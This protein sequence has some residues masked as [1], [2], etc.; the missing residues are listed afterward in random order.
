MPATLDLT[1][2]KRHFEE[3]KASAVSDEIINLNV[4]SIID[5]R[6]V[7]KILGRNT[8]RKWGLTSDL[9]P[10]WYA[11]GCDPLTGMPTLQGVQVKP[12]KAPT[13]Q[14]GKPQKY[15]GASG[16]ETAPLFLRTGKGDL[17]E[18]LIDDLSQWIFICEG[19]KK[20]GSLLSID[21]PAIS[22]PGVTTCRKLG[23]LHQN[24][25]LFAKPGRNI[26][27]SYDNDLMY[28]KGVQDGLE[29]LGRELRAAGAKVWVLLLPEGEAKGID[30]FLALHGEEAFRKLLQSPESLPTFEEWLEKKKELEQEEEEKTPKSKF[31]KKFY[32]IQ[33]AWGEDLRYNSLKQRIELKGR[34]LDADE[35]QVTLFEHFDIDISKQDAYTIVRTL[36]KRKTYSPVLDYL[37]EVE[38]KFPDVDYSF[39]DDLAKL[40]FGSDNPLHAKYLKNFLVA[41]VA[42]TRVPGIKMDCAVLLT[43]KQGAGKSTFWETLFGKDFFSDDFG[44]GSDKDEKMKMHRF[45][46]LEWSE[47]TSVYKRKDIEQLKNFIARKSDSYRAPYDLQP[48]EHLRSFLFTGTSN[49][50]EMLNDP[51]GD[52]RFWPIPITGKIPIDL[53]AKMRDQIWAAAN[54]LYKTGYKFHLNDQDDALREIL[55]KEYQAVDPWED[56]ISRF[57]VNRDYVTVDEIYH[58]LSIEPARR[59]VYNLRR[60]TGVLKRLGHKDDRIYVGGVRIRA[61]VKEVKDDNNNGIKNNFENANF[62]VP[63][64][65]QENQIP[66]NHSQQALDLSPGENDNL[67][68]TSQNNSPVKEDN[69]NSTVHLEPQGL[70]A[71]WDSGTVEE[72][73]NK[74]PLSSTNESSTELVQPQETAPVD[75]YS[76]P[77]ADDYYRD[78]PPKPHEFVVDTLYGPCKV[79]A[80]P[81]KKVKDQ[82]KFHLLFEMEKGRSCSEC[83][84][85]SDKK[86]I[87]KFATDSKALVALVEAIAKLWEKKAQTR[88][89]RVLRDRENNIWVEGCRIFSVPSRKR[90]QNFFFLDAPDGTRYHASIDEIQE[91]V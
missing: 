74:I 55:N 34:V 30:D 33:K 13:G 83:Q 85:V 61:W 39:L 20:S 65:P 57:V 18:S 27:L 50:K 52:R 21:I 16:M 3:W 41:A 28:K 64:V 73:Q 89:Y 71:S 59:D 79:V 36:A 58:E 68:Y 90:H 60:I 24:L 53:V 40:F 72:I 31:G 63:A 11:S 8:S 19:A 49:E 10:G 14:N 17:W 37:N 44:D 38:A 51:S 47:F 86:K 62:A 26:V 25:A 54:A 29:G 45:W 23:R 56:M 80:T 5:P 7:N 70:Q 84:C 46:C 81:Y 66:E 48:N 12:D 1:L 9:V 6:Q 67:F 78:F 88:T 22:V 75:K 87:E 4:M 32:L 35:L 91:M 15:I 69:K 77:P 42:R 76:C 82:S 43:G 2:E